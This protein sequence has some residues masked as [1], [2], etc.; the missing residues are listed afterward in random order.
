M[1]PLLASFLLPFLAQTPGEL[2]DPKSF[3]SIGWLMVC[4]AALF[5]SWNQLTGG[6]VNFRKLKGADPQADGRYAT[7]NEHNSL[8]EKVAGHDGQLQRL[9][10]TLATELREINR[11]LGRLEGAVGTSPQHKD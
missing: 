11:A 8:A 4:L 5:A 6:I 10:G 7:K 1:P 2:P 9:N 3:Q